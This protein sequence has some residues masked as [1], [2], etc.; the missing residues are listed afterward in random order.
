MLF[1]FII[2]VLGIGG[3][4]YLKKKKTFESNKDL[5]VTMNVSTSSPFD[6]SPIPNKKLKSSFISDPFPTVNQPK[7]QISKLKIYPLNDAKKKEKLRSKFVDIWSNEQAYDDYEFNKNPTQEQAISIFDALESEHYLYHHI[8]KNTDDIVLN[9]F[10]KLFPSICY[11]DAEKQRIST[12]EY[13]LDEWTDID[14][15]DY[16]FKKVPTQ[17]QCLTVFEALEKANVSYEDIDSDRGIVL[18]KFRVL[19]PTITNTPYEID[20]L[21]NIEDFLDDWCLWDGNLGEY[22]ANLMKKP[23]KKQIE[24]V[25]HELIVREKYPVNDLFMSEYQHIIFNKLVSLY[26]DLK[27]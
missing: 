17:K 22:R 5:V 27:K 8:L 25:F 7:K 13:F 2:I 11:S 12:L 19:F 26:P 10:R 20:F 14:L 18:E 23:T 4:F 15:E 6:Q 9:K 21:C 24:K 3:Y 16:E 1:L